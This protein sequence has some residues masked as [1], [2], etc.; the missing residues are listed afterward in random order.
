[1]KIPAQPK[2]VILGAGFA[3]VRIALDLAKS[4]RGVNIV[5]INKNPYHEFHADLYEVANTILP[6]PQKEPKLRLA[7]EHLKGSV[8]IPL[9]KIFRSTKVEIVIDEAVSLDFKNKRLGLKGGKNLKYDILVLALGSETNYFGILDLEKYSLPLKTVDDALNIRNEIDEVF[10]R[11]KEKEKISIIV[12]GGGFTGCEL[13]GELALYVQDL[14]K[15]H[16]HKKHDITLSIVEACPALIN[17]VKRSVQETAEKRL[18]AL[19]IKLYLNSKITKV[20]KKMVHAEPHL[21]IPYDV[22]VWTAGIKA[23]SFAS[24]L[25]GVHVEKTCLIVD[26][27]LRVIPL[28]NVFAI[29]DIAY[30]FDEERSCPVPA[31]AQTAIHQGSQTAKNISRLLKG[32]DL[33]LYKPKMPNFIIPLGGKFAAAE[34]GGFMLEGIDA[35]WLKRA[36][37]LRYFASILPSSEAF[38][39]WSEGNKFFIAND[40]ASVDS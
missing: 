39:I 14:S 29:G 17:G 40:S 26:K 7:Y 31:T 28:K 21:A 20:S 9:E 35:W 22:L 32:E 23:N 30:C 18:R 11:K 2:I 37:A 19:G 25:T 24:N 36:A 5:L 8:A 34:I 6:E 27:T 1:M 12:G 3:G 13:A 38:Q 15:I 4:S 16:A 10:A 33:V